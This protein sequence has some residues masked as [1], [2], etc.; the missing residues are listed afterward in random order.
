MSSSHVVGG[1]W[2]DAL[3]ILFMLCVL[4]ALLSC[5]SVNTDSIPSPTLAYLLNVTAAE[6]SVVRFIIRFSF[7]VSQI[8]NR[9]STPNSFFD[10]HF[11]F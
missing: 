2:N 9:I 7:C 3:I 4:R 8:E 1:V 10:F 11:P 5:H 6:R